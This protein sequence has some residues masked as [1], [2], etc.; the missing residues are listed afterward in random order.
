MRVLW[1]QCVCLLLFF[2]VGGFLLDF[3]GFK[4]S[5]LVSF[6]KWQVT[7]RSKG[8]NENI[9]LQTIECLKTLPAEYAKV[10]KRA[11][12]CDGV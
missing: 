11:K 2:G 1:W 8:E 12:T 6:A 3:F 10:L 5:F 9:K 4:T 7:R